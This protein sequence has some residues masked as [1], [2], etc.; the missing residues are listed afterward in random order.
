MKPICSVNGGWCILPIKIEYRT[1]SPFSGIETVPQV[2][3]TGVS[4]G[5]ECGFT[6]PD[7]LTFAQFMRDYANCN[8]PIYFIE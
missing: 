7:G 6:L 4:G 5:R 3:I 8:D 1:I 2:Y